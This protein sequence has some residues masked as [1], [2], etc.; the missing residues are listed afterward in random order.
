MPRTVSSA[1]PAHAG[2]VHEFA[3]PFLH[4]PYQSDQF[5][6]AKRH[7]S[8]SRGAAPTAPTAAGIRLAAA[9]RRPALPVLRARV[10]RGA[11]RP[12]P[13]TR[14]LPRRRDQPHGRI[15]MVKHGSVGLTPFAPRLLKLSGGACP[16]AGPRIVSATRF[17]V[18]FI[19][20]TAPCAWGC[21]ELRCLGPTV[22]AGMSGA[23]RGRL[24]LAPYGRGAA[25]ARTSAYCLGGGAQGL[26][27]RAS[28]AGASESAKP[29]AGRGTEVRAAAHCCPRCISAGR[30]SQAHT[31]AA[32]K[33]CMR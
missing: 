31:L 33:T 21:R 32:R 12:G 4:G 28:R 30:R 15:S 6:E 8:L 9:A 24:S 2:Y 22:T 16:A 14:S 7:S 25:E 13:A 3:R 23:G 27:P 18:D 1:P 10:G 5:V 19:L 11:A 17:R 20:L 26:A 29:A